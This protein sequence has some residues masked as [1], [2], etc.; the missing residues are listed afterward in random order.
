MPTVSLTTFVDFVSKAGTPKFT[1]VK[2]WKHKKPY[3]PATDFYK[4][5]RDE[6]TDIHI[7]SRPISALD[8]LLPTLKDSK[9]Q[10]IYPQIISGYKRWLGR[11]QPTW[12]SPP[13]TIWTHIGLD[14]AVNPELG[15]MIDGTPHLIKMYF[16]SEPLTKNRIEIITHLMDLTRHPGLPKDCKMAVLDVRQSKLITP[17]VPVPGLTAQLQ[18]EAAYWLAVWPD[19]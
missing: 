5:I 6:I 15:L 4:L 19:A 3:T 14:V 8:D 10:E 18:G 13:S 17:S 11:K 2:N 1:V 16:K 7:K 12:F 9:R